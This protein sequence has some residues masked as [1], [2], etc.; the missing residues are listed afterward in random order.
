VGLTLVTLAQ[1]L[2]GQPLLVPDA[3]TLGS[4]S[5]VLAAAL[6]TWLMPVGYFGRSARPREV[7]TG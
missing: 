7:S 3:A 2:R 1:A 5:L 4:A 6:G